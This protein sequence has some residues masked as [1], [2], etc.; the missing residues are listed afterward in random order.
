MRPYV[1]RSDPA[2]N[3][4]LI[5]TVLAIKIA[6]SNYKQLAE[7]RSIPMYPVIGAAPLPFR[8]GISPKTVE[9][10]AD[11]YKGI[12]TT[13]IQS[14][15][16][17]DF[18]KS[19]VLHA[20]AY[21]ENNLSKQE[22]I[23]ISTKEQKELEKI[24]PLFEESYK[25][26]IEDISPLINTIAAHLPRRRERVQHVGLFGYSRGVGKVKLPR[27]IGFTASLYSIGIPPEFIGTGRGLDKAK[28]IGVIDFIKKYYIYLEKDLIRAGRYL[29]KENLKHLAQKSPAWKKILADVTAIEKI[30]GISL[31]PKTQEEKEHHALTGAIYEKIQ[32]GLPVQDFIEQAAILRK[33]LG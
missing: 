21:L 7:K 12:R 17:Y 22:A 25:E 6:L 18:E 19:D 1:A 8:G 10:F 29:H 5:P 27:A 14:A 26:V 9:D 20:I 23:N 4:G 28:K 31:E 33:S 13:T 2:L 32:H 30:L 3:S 24:I 16:R 11:E 15:F